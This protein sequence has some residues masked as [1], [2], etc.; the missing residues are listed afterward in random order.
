MF[1]ST[2]HHSLSAKKGI[3]CSLIRALSPFCPTCPIQTANSS[4]IQKFDT[5]SRKRR[6]Y[7]SATLARA[8]AL[9][10]IWLLLQSFQAWW[11]Q[12][13]LVAAGQILPEMHCEG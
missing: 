12:L 13:C 11:R 5:F 10:L 1:D 9:R 2:S 8:L 7:R 6:N 3:G 4:L